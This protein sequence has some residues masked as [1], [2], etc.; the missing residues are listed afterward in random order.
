[1]N[2]KPILYRCCDVCGENPNV[3]YPEGD[4]QPQLWFCRDCVGTTAMQD[5]V[6]DW[7]MNHVV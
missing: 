4:E 6:D 2:F 7:N 3:D 1:M 5:V